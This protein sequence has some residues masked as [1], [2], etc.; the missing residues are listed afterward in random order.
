MISSS[1]SSRA[2][3]KL[4]EPHRIPATSVKEDGPSIAIAEHWLLG[5]V[6]KK[7]FLVGILVLEW[8]Q[9]SLVDRNLSNC[10]LNNAIY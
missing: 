4:V 1:I 10:G 2:P 6:A 3:C 9:W 5:R 8:P 7:K